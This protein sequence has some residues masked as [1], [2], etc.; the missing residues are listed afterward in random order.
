MNMGKSTLQIPKVCPY[1]GMVFYAK[2]VTTVYCSRKCLW[3]ACNEKKKEERKLKTRLTILKKVRDTGDGYVTISKALQIFVTSRSTIRRLILKNKIGYV[4]VSAK[5]IFV[6][7]DSL[8]RMFPLQKSTQE[9][10]P[11][12]RADVF[13]MS[14]NNCYTIG[15][16]SKIYKVTEYSVYHHIRKYSVPTRQIG[17]FVYAPK[18]E[19]EKLYNNQNPKR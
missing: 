19:I 9:P 4:R 17:R 3:T 7:I 13:D 10:M 5:K 15:E 14:P 2:T 11:T 8:E 6:S 12:M 1:C 18:S 16:I